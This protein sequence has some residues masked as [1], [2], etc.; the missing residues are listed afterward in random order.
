[1]LGHL[2][3]LLINTDNTEKPKILGSDYLDIISLKTFYCHHR[4]Y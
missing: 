4:P 3:N 2:G 1:M